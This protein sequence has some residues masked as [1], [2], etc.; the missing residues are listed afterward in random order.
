MRICIISREYPPETGWG[1][2]ATFAKH[3]AHGLT[4][5]GHEVEVISLTLDKPHSIRES[6]ILVHRVQELSVGG[7]LTRGGDLLSYTRYVL[8]TSAAMWKKFIEL[9]KRKPFDVVDTP[10]LL[11]EGVWPAITKAAPLA[12]RLYTPHSKFIAERLH[13]VRPSLDHQVVAAFERVAMLQADVLTSPSE[14]LADFVSL[15]LNYPREKIRLI[16]NPIDA[17]VFKPEGPTAFMPE[18]RL[19]VLFVGRLEERKGIHYLIDAIPSIVAEFKNVRF[20]I[21][22]DDTK[23]AEGHRSVL[24]ELK[25]K[26]RKNQL[27]QHIEWVQRVPLETLP[28]YYRSADICVVPSVYDNSP[29]TCL[30]AMACGRAVV[31][32]S[33]GGTREYIINGESGIIVPP[34]DS[35]AL[36]QSIL[37]LLKNPDMRKQLATAAR[38]RVLTHFQRKEIA[39]QTVELYNEAIANFQKRSEFRMYR[40]DPSQLADDLDQFFKALDD[41]IYDMLFLEPAFRVA[42]YFKLFKARPKLFLARVVLS[43]VQKTFGKRS[44]SWSFVQRL[45]NQVQEKSTDASKRKKTLQAAGKQ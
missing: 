43:V 45:Q 44:N 12:V 30:E 28:S 9:H 33:A 8:G 4:D 31:G 36:S 13:N 16:R 32:T 37:Q 1:G 34:R 11:A 23:T 15:D 39:R 18:G 14:D 7:G 3:L 10:E 41:G 35:E 5:L 42:H 27:E 2:I 29:Y 24:A 22:G 25:E 6:G 20:V 38:E 17:T 40:R 19:T 21:L 26:V